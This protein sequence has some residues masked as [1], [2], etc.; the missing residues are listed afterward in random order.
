MITSTEL[1][2]LLDE[3]KP[4][5]NFFG[6]EYFIKIDDKQEI[7]FGKI[8]K[9]I[10]FIRNSNGGTLTTNNKEELFRYDHALTILNTY[11]KSSIF[12]YEIPNMVELKAFV[13]KYSTTN[14]EFRSR[15]WSNV[16]YQEK[17]LTY[18]FNEY[19]QS[20]LK[21][22]YVGKLLMIRRESY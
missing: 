5:I 17:M 1:I 12:K 22:T 18:D 14:E 15:F 21:N 16:E 8:Y 10:I 4:T 3:D 9:K 6:G 13:T 11:N 7:I 19:I 2:K 20:S